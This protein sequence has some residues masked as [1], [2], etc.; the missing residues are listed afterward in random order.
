MKVYIEIV[1]YRYAVLSDDIKKSFNRSTFI[2]TDL[3][4]RSLDLTIENTEKIRIEL[5]T[6][7][8]MLNIYL[9]E[10]ISHVCHIHKSFDFNHYFTQPKPEHRKIILETLYEAIVALCQKT[11]YNLALFTGAYNKVKELDYENRFIYGKLKSSPNRKNKAG[12]EIEVTEESANISIIFEAQNG[13]QNKVEILRTIPHYLFIYRFIYKGK[14]ADNEIFKVFNRSGEINFVTSL[15]N[16]SVS[17]QLLPVK[18]TEKE[19]K[20]AL[21]DIT[22]G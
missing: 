17:I 20:K 14:W 3:F 8:D 4:N 7:L 12:I 22:A 2:I 1:C 6:E 16:K 5:A 10:G 9:P 21:L 19:L 11:G 13:E 18:H 15:K